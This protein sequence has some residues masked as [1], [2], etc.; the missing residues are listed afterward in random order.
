[1]G[2]T[3]ALINDINETSVS[4]LNLIVTNRD[5]FKNVTIAAPARDEE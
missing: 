5:K 4:V 3:Q 2:R 1:M